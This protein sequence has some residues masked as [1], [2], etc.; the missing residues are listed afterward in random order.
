MSEPMSNFT[1]R[2][3]QVLALHVKQTGFITP[4]VRASSSRFNKFRSG[5]GGQC[6]VGLDLDTVRQ[7]VDE[8]VGLKPEAKP[9]GNIPYTPGQKGFSPAGKEAN[10]STTAVGMNI[11]CLVFCTGLPPGCLNRWMMYRCRNEI[12]LN[13][14]PIL[15][16]L[17][18][19]I[20]CGRGRW[21]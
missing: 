20:F 15:L 8:Q 2:A 13:S 12:F 19:R 16:P 4:S 21:R 6:S 7:A 5:C 10:R 1:P 3:Q 14:I 17:K 9:S 18:K 11:F